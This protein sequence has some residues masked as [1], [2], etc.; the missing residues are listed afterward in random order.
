MKKFVVNHDG[1]RP[2]F[3]G[4]VFNGVGD[5]FVKEA[6]LTFSSPLLGICF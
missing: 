2:L 3:W 6:V 4:F 1:F 5:I